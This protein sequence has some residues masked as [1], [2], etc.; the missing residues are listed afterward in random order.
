MILI[1]HGRNQKI[2][3]IWKEISA[4]APRLKPAA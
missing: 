3:P 1:G 4:G 2:R